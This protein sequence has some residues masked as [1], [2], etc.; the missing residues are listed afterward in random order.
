MYHQSMHRAMVLCPLRDSIKVYAFLTSFFVNSYDSCTFLSS[1]IS[2]KLLF[3]KGSVLVQAWDSVFGLHLLPS[4]PNGLEHVAPGVAEWHC[5]HW[6]THHRSHD[7]APHARP[8]TMTHLQPTP[9]I[10]A[11]FKDLGICLRIYENS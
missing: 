3:G 8:R 5:N 2:P 9:S 11:S 7:H 6:T 1:A 10:A 4:V